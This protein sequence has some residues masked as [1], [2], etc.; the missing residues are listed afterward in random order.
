M[1]QVE[2]WHLLVSELFDFSKNY[3]LQQ[4]RFYE[5]F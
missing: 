5:I 4:L 2:L 1:P 3:N